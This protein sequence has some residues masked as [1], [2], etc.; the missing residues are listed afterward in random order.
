MKKEIK[1]AENDKAIFYINDFCKDY[2]DGYRII[3][4]EEKINKRKEYLLLKDNEIIYGS[5]RIEDVW[6]R[7]DVIGLIKNRK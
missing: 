7:K 3:I 2:K 1:I 6:Y 4:A 5:Q